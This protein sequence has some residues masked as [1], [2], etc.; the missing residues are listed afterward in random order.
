MQNFKF[1]LAG[2]P[3]NVYFRNRLINYFR[4]LSVKIVYNLINAPLV[5]GNGRCGNNYRVVRTDLNLIVFARGH[6]GKR[7]HRLALTAGRYDNE[8]FI[9]N[10]LY[11]F[12]VDNYI[13]RNENFANLGRR[14]HYV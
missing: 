13:L 2:V 10:A 4:T 12:Y 8:I 1:F 9:G 7:A 6:T 5:T 3:R 14:L 11:F